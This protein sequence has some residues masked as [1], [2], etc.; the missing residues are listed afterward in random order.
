MKQ[1]PK[2]LPFKGLHYN[3]QKI[4]D[5]SCVVTP[6]YDVIS[7]DYQKELDARSPYNFV[8][9]DYSLEEGEAR[10]PAS[11]KRFLEW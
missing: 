1:T 7:P 8:K 10:Y 11:Q 3:T 5:M 6:P 2:I 9:I 4:A